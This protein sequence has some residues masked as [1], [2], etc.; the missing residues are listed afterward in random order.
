MRNKREIK[1]CA[2]GYFLSCDCEIN[3]VLIV[4]VELMMYVTV[5]FIFVFLEVKIN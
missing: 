1:S 3:D 5:I 4:I 2:K